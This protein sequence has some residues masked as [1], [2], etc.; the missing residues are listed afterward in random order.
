MIQDIRRINAHSNSLVSVT[1]ILLIRFMSNCRKG[2]PSIH[3][4]P[5]EPICPGADFCTPPLPCE[6]GIFHP[7]A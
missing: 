3:F 2:G 7:R 5:N 1:R 4:R 6:E